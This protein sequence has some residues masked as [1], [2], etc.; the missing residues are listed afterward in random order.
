[1]WH[2]RADDTIYAAA[3]RGARVALLLGAP[4]AALPSLAAM[5][6]GD[7]RRPAGPVR[8]ST[9][10]APDANPGDRPRPTR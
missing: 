8:R 5:L 1:V 3:R 4:A 9:R 10:P 2:A 7:G 6:D